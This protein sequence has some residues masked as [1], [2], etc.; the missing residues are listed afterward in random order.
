MGCGVRLYDEE[1]EEGDEEGDEELEELEGCLWPVSVP[2]MDI[3]ESFK[4]ILL[5]QRIIS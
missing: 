3:S 5:L 4:K 2:Q 1:V